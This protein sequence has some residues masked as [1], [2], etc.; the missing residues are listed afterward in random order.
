[1]MYSF[2][3][4]FDYTLNILTINFQESKLNYS[5]IYQEDE[6]ASRENHS[7]LAIYEIPDIAPF[8]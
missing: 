5:T 3:M 8:A 6:N 7:F 2:L 1:M 4:K